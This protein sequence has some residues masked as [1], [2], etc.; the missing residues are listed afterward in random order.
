MRIPQPLRKRDERRRRCT[1]LPKPAV[2]RLQHVGLCRSAQV[3]AIRASACGSGRAQGW[4]ADGR[5]GTV[6]RQVRPGSSV[7]SESFLHHS[8]SRWSLRSAGSPPPLSL[9][10]YL[11]GQAEKSAS[12]KYGKRNARRDAAHKLSKPRTTSNGRSC[13]GLNLRQRA[14]C[15]HSV[16]LT[17]EHGRRSSL[18]PGS[19]RP[20]SRPAS[21][22]LRIGRSLLRRIFFE[23]CG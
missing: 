6:R 1:L 5:G 23:G 7:S 12:C 2:A 21:E 17:A 10:S 14:A 19:C 4:V 9:D 11:G 3:L 18:T 13:L 8:G 16:G 22:S 20:R 15:V